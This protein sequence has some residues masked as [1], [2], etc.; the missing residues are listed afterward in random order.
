ML[1]CI[2]QIA[3]ANC[4]G[5]YAAARGLVETLCSIVWASEV[6][7]RLCLHLS[8]PSGSISGEC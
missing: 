7:E 5:F 6:S 1:C 8:V 3:G 4:N 2:D